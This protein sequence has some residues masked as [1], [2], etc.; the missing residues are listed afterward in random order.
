MLQLLI[1]FVVLCFV[2]FLTTGCLEQV[3]FA[4]DGLV[5]RLGIELRREA[6]HQGLIGV[7]LILARC[8]TYAP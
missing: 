2:V 8:L 5:T 1:I 4:V 3:D 6:R 7:V